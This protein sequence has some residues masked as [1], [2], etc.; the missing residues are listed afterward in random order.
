[1]STIKI[2]GFSFFGRA[3]SYACT[4]FCSFVFKHF[5][6]C[7]CKHGSD[8]K[9]DALVALCVGDVSFGSFYGCVVYCY[10]SLFCHDLTVVFTIFN[11]NYE[12]LNLNISI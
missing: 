6:E 9:P 2:F 8:G 3:M 5:V 12:I 11:W 7:Q 1:M 10:I 4:R